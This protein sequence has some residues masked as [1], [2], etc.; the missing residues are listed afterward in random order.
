MAEHLIIWLDDE[1]PTRESPARWLVLDGQGNRVGH[2]QQGPLDA[3][4]SLAEQRRVVVL[5]HGESLL[6]L[7]A[8]IPG[9]NRNTILKAIPYA[10]EDR[11]AEDIETLHFALLGKAEDD[12]HTVLV[13]NRKWLA[14]RLDA[15]REAGIQA[16]ALLPDYL[17]LPAP[18]TGESAVV[19]RER[20]LVRLADGHGFAA[21]LDY[22]DAV[23]TDTDTA[24]Q[25]LEVEDPAADGASAEQVIAKLP[26]RWQ[27]LVASISSDQL[28]TRL[29]R[30]A[31]KLGPGLLQG[32]LARKRETAGKLAAWRLP[33]ALAALSL[34]VATG[35]WGADVWRLQQEAAALEGYSDTLYRRILPN[36]RPTADPRSRIEPLLAGGDDS[37]HTGIAMIS[38]LGLAM[39]DTAGIELQQ[40]SYR[41]NRLEIRVVVPTAETL[42]TLRQ[43]LEASSPYRVAISSANAEGEALE[44]RMTME[45]SP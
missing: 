18:A 32:A 41:N 29:A 43:S 15:L 5:L 10:L 21:P 37:D 2:P 9:R 25:A 8:S 30:E 31:C 22:L 42:E 24:P 1:L 3:A 6:L 38:T 20:L 7:T 19:S 35:L 12:R 27:S 45:A 11:L 26:A 16:D 34:L 13:G 44:G 33:A 36:A 28:L 4:A 14:A 17:A 40:I 23:W 39:N